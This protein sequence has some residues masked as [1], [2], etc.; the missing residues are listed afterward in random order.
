MH[1]W[2]HLLLLL[3]RRHYKNR[4]CFLEALYN[5]KALRGRSLLLRSSLR[6]KAR[7]TKR[8]NQKGRM[9]RLRRKK[10]PSLRS[11]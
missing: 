11:T 6:Q 7:T 2:Q 5:A 3:L 10:S 8:K 4:Q 9:K 1:S